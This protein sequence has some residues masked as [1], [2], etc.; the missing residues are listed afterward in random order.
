MIQ[1]EYKPEQ[2]NER[3]YH[4]HRANNLVYY[5]YPTRVEN[6]PQLVYQPRQSEPP[7]QCP[8]HNTQIPDRH[9]Y[10]MVGYYKGE[11]RK[12]RHEKEYDERIAERHEKRRHGVM[13]ERALPVGTLMGVLHRVRLEAIDTKD[14]KHQRTGNLQQILVVLIVD[15]V[16]HKAHAKTGYQC[17]YNI[18][19]RCADTRDETIPAAFVESTLYAQYTNRPHRGGSDDTDKDS[20]EYAI[21]NIY[22]KWKGQIHNRVQNCKNYTK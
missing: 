15:E 22:L 3:E 9:F 21:K 4:D 10:R 5:Y 16:H 6:I 19:P 7:Q 17:I 8:K 20:L 13:G 12:R 2:G 18:A 1:V 14:Q 11:L